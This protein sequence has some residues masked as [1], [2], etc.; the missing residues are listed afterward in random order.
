MILDT[1]FLI[2]L[3]QEQQAAFEKAIEMQE[4]GVIPRVP[5][6][7]LQELEYGASFLD[8]EETIRKVRNIA[9]MYPNVELTTNDHTRAGQLHAQADK[10]TS[11][12]DAGVDDIDAMLGAVSQRF[13]EPVLTE[14]TDDFDALGVSTATWY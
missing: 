10:A 6:P 12:D 4:E 1:N 2:R 13:S 11:G 9:L 14:N 7:V 8:D 5:A 3:Y